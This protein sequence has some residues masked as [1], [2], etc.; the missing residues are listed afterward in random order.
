MRLS[1]LDGVHVAGKGLARW[2]H[3]SRRLCVAEDR[4]DSQV[5]AYFFISCELAA[6]GDWRCAQPALPR[7]KRVYAGKAPRPRLDL[8]RCHSWCPCQTH[9]ARLLLRRQQKATA[10][11]DGCRRA[12][13][14]VTAAS[15][16]SHLHTGL[17]LQVKSAR[18]DGPGCAVGAVNASSVCADRGMPDGIPKHM[19][20]MG[21]AAAHYTYACPLRAAS[22]ECCFST[23]SPLGPGHKLGV[24][25]ACPPGDSL[26]CCCLVRLY[27]CFA[28]VLAARLR[29]LLVA[30]PCS[31]R[32]C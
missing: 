21:A 5:L 18:A 17:A 25:V 7:Q 9:A 22:Q 23:H 31:F 16:L 14:A 24:H 26:C 4:Q 12:G 32:S 15:P 3:G 20:G 8:H 2:V 13:C 30:F 6:C 10:A 28:M 19:E 1:P 27:R 29:L 11:N